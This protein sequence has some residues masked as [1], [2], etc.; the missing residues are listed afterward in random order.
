MQKTRR[1]YLYSHRC[2]NIYVHTHPYTRVPGDRLAPHSAP[3]HRLSAPVHLS[4]VRAS[5]VRPYHKNTSFDTFTS[6]IHPQTAPFP[7][8]HSPVHLTRLPLRRT[9]CAW[10]FVSHRF[11]SRTPSINHLHAYTAFHFHSPRG[12]SLK[13]QPAA[14]AVETAIV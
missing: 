1:C 2:N 7:V 5:C 3:I 14:R 9:L 13:P 11:V 10:S 6:M 12:Q 4:R 8:I